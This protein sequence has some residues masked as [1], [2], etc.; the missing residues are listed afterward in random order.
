MNCP[1][2]GKENQ[3]NSSTCD[4][5]GAWIDDPA[6]VNTPPGLQPDSASPPAETALQAGLEPGGSATQV[7]ILPEIQALP[8]VQ[9]SKTGIDRWI[10][11]L[12]G[13]SVLFC[14]CA[15][16]VTLTWGFYT[17]STAFNFF[18]PATATPPPT[19]TPT[20]LFMD[21]FSDPTSGWPVYNDDQYMDDYYN[22]AYRMV[23]NDINTT[24]WVYPDEFD[25]N[26]VLIKV[27]A[28][29][30]AGPD[31]ND[32][33]LICRYQNE[34]QFYAGI[35][36]SD[37]YY[38]ITKMTPD[39]F[40]VIGG[41]YLEY[42]DLINQGSATNTI[43]FDCVGDVFTL[44]VNGYQLDQRTDTEYIGGTFGLI[45][46]TY[47]TPGTDILYDNFSAFEP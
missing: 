30:N 44:Y 16:C 23:E 21:D 19:P 31:E 12:V 36:T 13:C 1:F 26:D 2:C 9:K 14:L 28:T 3:V 27:D 8:A 32:M 4:F 38:G 7:E 45:I 46:G 20:I 42:S 43:Q 41:E 15:S 11:W 37:G 10:W 24:S 22:G 34:D 17:Y 29:K 6:L 39:D 25:V 35:I 5:C 18:K 40:L 47:E 33:G